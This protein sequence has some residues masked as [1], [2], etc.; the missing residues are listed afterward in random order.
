MYAPQNQIQIIHC[1]NGWLLIIPVNFDVPVVQ[2]GSP[3]GI[4]MDDA[5]KFFQEV[6]DKAHADPLLKELMKE[7]EPEQQQHEQ[8]ETVRQLDNHLVF[9]KFSELLSWLKKNYP[10][11][12]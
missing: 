7:K 3:F 10:L 5:V 12:K 2:P 11:Y 9:H 6:Q 1:R 4:N 8:S